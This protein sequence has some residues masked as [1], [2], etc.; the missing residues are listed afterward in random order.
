VSSKLIIDI[1]YSN[2]KSFFIYDSG[3]KYAYVQYWQGSQYPNQRE[4]CGLQN[5]NYDNFCKG[6]SANGSAQRTVSI[7][8]AGTA[9]CYRI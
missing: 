6:L 5:T 7:N 9:N 2:Q 4:C 8:M 1:N 3:G